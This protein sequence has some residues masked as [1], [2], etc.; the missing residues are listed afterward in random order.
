MRRDRRPTMVDPR[1]LFV[2]LGGGRGNEC[3]SVEQEQSI[4]N[5]RWYCVQC[6]ARWRGSW[7]VIRESGDPQR[8]YVLWDFVFHG[9]LR[10]LPVDV[11][12]RSFVRVEHLPLLQ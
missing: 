7:P 4:V 5:G 12:D 2:C 3:L 10:G 9:P 6:R 11:I 8:R 1:F